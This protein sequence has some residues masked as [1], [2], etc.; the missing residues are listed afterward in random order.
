MGMIEHHREGYC[1]S[2][3][4][5]R[6]L[7]M[8]EVEMLVEVDRICKKCGIKYC[9]S[10]GTQLGA[11]RHKG[12]I[13]WDDDADVAFLRSEY[14]KFRDACETELDRDRFYFQDYRNTPG[15][16][17]GYGKLRRKN[18]KFVRL[19]QEHMPYEQG[20][21]IDIMPYDNVPDFYLMRKWHNFRCF[22]YRKAF[23]APLGKQQE[24]GLKKLAYTLLDRVPDE[25]IYRS[26]T[27]FTKRCNRR[28]TKRI[29]ICAFPVPGH[30]NGYLRKCFEELVPTVF[31]SVELMGMKNYE[32]YLSYKYGD[33][34]TLP[35]VEK[36]K[37]HPV[38][39]LVL[40]S[41]NEKKLDE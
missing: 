17:W 8:L 6:E 39:K 24:T 10:A 34:M 7:Q 5:L 26:F 37:V 2:E 33:Y 27:N 38:S 20:V 41:Q 40:L 19:Y 13:P 31:E 25:K 15:Y 3:A 14:E 18:T 36:R 35:P 21:F 1:L 23:W 22:L 4:E 16:R 9:I 32:E 12:F 30:E 29:R 11:V 28:E